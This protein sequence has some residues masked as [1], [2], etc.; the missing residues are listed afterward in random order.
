MAQHPANEL[1]KPIPLAL[2]ICLMRISEKMKRVLEA[3]ALTSREGCCKRALA[4]GLEEDAAVEVV[5]VGI[6]RTLWA[7]VAEASYEVLD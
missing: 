4:N 1:G 6:S 5:A 3:R 2:K 7:Q